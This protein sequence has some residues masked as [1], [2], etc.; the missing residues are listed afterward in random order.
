LWRTLWHDGLIVHFGFF[1]LPLA[2]VGMLLLARRA[3]EAASWLLPV[4]MALTFLI[5][6]GFAVLPFISGST[7]ATR[8]LMF[9]AWAV[10]IAAACCGQLLWR[11]GRAGRVVVLACA[12]F[13]AFVT[14][15]QWLAA[16][17]WRVRPPEPF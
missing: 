13:I 8:W 5:M 17:A 2:V 7:L 3:R 16:L 4:L 1:P 11:A 9:G 6:A 12:G 10:A 15:A 14:L